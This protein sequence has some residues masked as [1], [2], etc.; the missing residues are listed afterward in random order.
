MAK[1]KYDKLQIYYPYKDKLDMDK[2]KC[3]ELYNLFLE[4]FKD[5]ES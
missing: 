2:E 4:E 1:E 5:Y 3:N